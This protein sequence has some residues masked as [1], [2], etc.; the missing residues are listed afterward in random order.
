[1]T[2]Q[3]RQQM[4]EFLLPTGFI[5]GDGA[6][7]NTDRKHCLV[8]IQQHRGYALPKDDVRSLRNAG[9]HAHL[10]QTGSVRIERTLLT[11]AV[12]AGDDG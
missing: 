2:E 10:L 6:A 3:T 11:G 1:M 5:P 7:R 12:D 9:G 4:I 8:Q